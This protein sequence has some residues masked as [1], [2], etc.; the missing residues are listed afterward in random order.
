MLR[1]TIPRTAVLLA[2]LLLAGNV[3]SELASAV[4]AIVHDAVI[5]YQEVQIFAA[6]AIETARR[7]FAGDRDG[8]NKKANELLAESLEQLVERQLILHDFKAAGYN[9]PESI[10]EE[11]VQ[12]R[13]K[14]RYGD[15]KTLTQTL[16]EQGMTYEKFRQQIRDQIIVEALR[17]KNISSEIIISPS[18][19][20][21]YYQEHAQNYQVKEQVKLRM[22]VLNKTEGT[23]TNTVLL[24]QEIVGKLKQGA[25]F[26]EMATVY[27]Q[28]SQRGE[29][30]DW[31]WADRASLRAELAD[32]AFKLK[33]GEFSPVVETREACFIMLVEDTK[34][35]HT[36]PLAEVQDEIERNLLVAERARLA[37]Q[38][39]DK[40]KKKTFVRYF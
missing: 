36:R 29:G 21:K 38:Y 30:G 9:L 24:G 6:P 14:E 3:R 15:R 8:F 31:G 33:A 23:G 32:V 17:A 20:E 10:I 27:S 25:S 18:K 37:A 1:M 35:A 16:K 28:G 12:D 39:I 5:T 26:A 19:I 40:L 11:S 22:I 2:A 7:Q 4:K 34:P 13:I